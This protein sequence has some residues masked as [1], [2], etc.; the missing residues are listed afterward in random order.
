MRI[1]YLAL[2]VLA[3]ILTACGDS[4]SDDPV[5]TGPHRFEGIWSAPAY[6]TVIEIDRD[7]FRQYDVT[8][9][10][11][12]I[13]E[14]ESGLSLA[15]YESVFALDQSGSELSDP[16]FNGTMNFHAPAVRYQKQSSL[17]EACAQPIS[18]RGQSGY[19]RDPL[20][21]YQIFWDTFD[22]L[23]VSFDNREVDWNAHYQ[24]SISQLNPGM[25][26]AAL[27]E[28]LYQHIESL[29][30]VH[31]HLSA[32]SVGEVSVSNQP[33]LIESLI[34]EYLE[35]N[36]L[37]LPLDPDQLAG[38]NGYIENNLSIYDMI[39]NDYADTP[40]AIKS[41]ANEQLKWFSVGQISYLRINAMTGF[42]TDPENS[43]ME[44][45]A[46]ERG[47][48]QAMADIQGSSGLIIDVRTNN[49]GSDFASLAIAARFIDSE[50]HVYS[51]QARLGDTTTNMIDVT[52]APRGTQ[53]YLGP[54]ALLTSAST[55]SAAEVFTLI[56]SSLPDVTLIGEPTQGAISDMLDKQLPNG[57]GFSLSNEFYYDIDGNW[58]EGEGIPVDIEVPFFTLQQRADEQDLALE[59]AFAALTE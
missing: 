2:P 57:F 25:D 38:I 18:Q 26:D 19:Q 49:G 35:A 37:E 6:G 46:L 34:N 30:D 8:R 21:D 23:Y 17:P 55:V 22:E 56:M 3:A 32:E 14:T 15:D 5:V 28:L 39:I 44:L 12:L 52:L 40:D 1:T 58:Y 41:A 7:R 42:S 48:D 31:V 24:S 47:L 53:Q 10:S 43:E 54:I 45:G 16:G 36:N 20:R 51:K 27:F 29:K 4:D 59:T 33:L 9:S 11:C 13:S 50:R